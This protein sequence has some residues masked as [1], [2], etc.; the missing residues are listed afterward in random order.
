MAIA[1]NYNNLVEEVNTIQ[2]EIYLKLTIL[3]KQNNHHLYAQHQTN[4]ALQ[5]KI[6]KAHVVVKLVIKKL[7]VK[8]ISKKRK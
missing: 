8:L 4:V 1:V 3:K 6:R 7:K 5:L 2:N